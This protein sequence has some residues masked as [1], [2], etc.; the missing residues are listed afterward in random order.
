MPDTLVLQLSFFCIFARLYSFRHLSRTGSS[1][2][3]RIFFV[4]KTLLLS[5][6][7]VASIISQVKMSNFKIVEVFACGHAR[8]FHN[9]TIESEMFC[10]TAM[11][12][13]PASSG[14]ANCL[15]TNA[16]CAL[17]A[18]QAQD[19]D[20]T[21]AEPV[22][23]IDE[24]VRVGLLRAAYTQACQKMCDVG[25]YLGSFD[26]ITLR[27]F[28][29]LCLSPVLWGARDWTEEIPIVFARLEEAIRSRAPRVTFEANVTH[30]AH[31][32]EAMNAVTQE[33]CDHG[34]K[35]AELQ[36]QLDLAGLLRNTIVMPK[37]F[38]HH[39]N[40]FW[41]ACE[42][43]ID[44]EKIAMRIFQ[45]HITHWSQV[46]LPLR[47]V[48]TGDVSDCNDYDAGLDFDD[49]STSSAE[50]EEE[51]ASAGQDWAVDPNI[52]FHPCNRSTR[53]QSPLES[54]FGTVFA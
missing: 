53:Q 45:P 54:P 38:E 10:A 40:I 4:D 52:I 46:T 24:R 41:A 48:N 27:T 25:D 15:Y 2:L 19:F 36:W 16:Y 49:G 47:V 26:E 50:S 9:G 17:P 3:S 33:M 39:T 29:D 23:D 44:R 20:P 22:Y 34:C 30:A 11:T 28:D 35:L 18:C 43:P 32:L 51:Q 5:T 37:D 31:L 13:I 6:A 8:S 7:P 42:E 12:Q 14:C 21:V 1:Q